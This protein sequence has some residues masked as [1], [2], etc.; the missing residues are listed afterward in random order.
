MQTLL[1]SNLYE[2]PVNTC[3]DI[4]YTF[5]ANSNGENTKNV[6]SIIKE[7]VIPKLK[8]KLDYAST[9]NLIDITWALNKLNYFEDKALWKSIFDKITTKTHTWQ[10]TECSYHAWVTDVYESYKGKGFCLCVKPF[11]TEF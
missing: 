11:E 4:L 8:E 2:F 1:R 6:N 9:Q 7:S 10:Y 5:A 3:A